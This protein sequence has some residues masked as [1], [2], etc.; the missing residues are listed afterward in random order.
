[1]RFRK[2]YASFD[3]SARQKRNGHD[4]KQCVKAQQPAEEHFASSLAAF[5]QYESV[6]GD[7]GPRDSRG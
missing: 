6:C 7:D 4:G 2:F 5:H 3:D 1:M